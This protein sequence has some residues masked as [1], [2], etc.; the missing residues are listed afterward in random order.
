VAGVEPF[1]SK[2]QVTDDQN[3]Y[4]SDEGQ[5]AQIDSQRFGSNDPELA[6]IVE[7]WGGLSDGYKRAIIAIVDSL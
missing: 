3:T 1:E 6:R 5:C 4:A 2:T 7:A